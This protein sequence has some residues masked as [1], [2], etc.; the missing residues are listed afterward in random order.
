MKGLYAVIMA[1]GSGTRFW[2]MSRE[3]WPKQMLK[4]V[5]EE[6]M[7]V[8]TMERVKGL[9]ARKNIHIVTTSNQASDINIHVGESTGIPLSL[10]TEPC[11][12]NTAP[13]IGLAAIHLKRRD[14]EAL[15]LVLPADHFIKNEKSF[16]STVR[17]GVKGASDGELVTI[18][19]QPTRPDTGYGYIRRGSGLGGDLYRVEQFVEKP[20][21]ETAEQYL[22]AGDYYWNSGIFIWKAEAILREIKAHMPALYMG[23]IRIDKALGTKREERVVREVY[24]SFESVSIDYGVM[25]QSKRVLMVPGDFEW[26]DVGSWS[27]LD[28][29]LKKDRRGNI[30]KRGDNVIDIESENCTI[31]ADNRVVATIGLKDMVVVD[32]ADATLICPKERCQDVK[33]VVSELEKRGREERLVHRTVERPWGSYTVLDAGEGYKLKRILVRPGGRLSLQLHHKRSEHWVVV[34][35]T[36]LVT[37]GE[38]VFD[39]PVNE[40]TYIPIGMKHRLENPGREPVQIIEVQHGNYLE[41]NDIVRFEDIYGR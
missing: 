33:M 11:A 36:A 35:G 22:E 18:G 21:L 7:I 17:R 26:S 29:L 40:S 20:D 39:L 15:M 13:A 34:A 24:D 28:E 14:P 5:G 41:E 6:S 9:V 38:E 37:R 31:Y 19:I 3:M 16:L 27:A 12:R 30:I 23:L 32:T 25:E 1:G 8:Q 10:I 2:P 4:I